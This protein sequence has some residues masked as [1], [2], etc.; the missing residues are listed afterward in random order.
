M[1]AFTRFEEIDA[2]KKGRALC[3]ELFSAC[4]E[5]QLAR[6]FVIRDQL[7]RAGISVPSNIAEG[8]GRNSHTE[9]ARFLDIS[10]ASA[11]EVQSILYNMLDFKLIQ[12]SRFDELYALANDAIALTTGLTSYLRKRKR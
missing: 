6:Q 7:I 5:P 11:C 4:S 12:Q 2:W 10:R 9:F 1:A 8:F 3:R